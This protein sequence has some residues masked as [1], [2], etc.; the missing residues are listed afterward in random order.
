[1]SN[2]INKEV[3]QRQGTPGQGLTPPLGEDVSTHF[4][5]LVR[6]VTFEDESLSSTTLLD[7]A[8]SSTS[9]QSGTA[10]ERIPASGVPLAEADQ[11]VTAEGKAE[12]D[13]QEPDPSSILLP[14]DQQQKKISAVFQ[15]LKEMQQRLQESEEST[16]TTDSTSVRS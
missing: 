6:R 5:T 15:Q 11:E 8:Q 9:A 14:E 2:P 13:E 16:L 7:T 3:N 12:E 10:N 4:T 1:M